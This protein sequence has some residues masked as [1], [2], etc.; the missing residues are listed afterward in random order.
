M[1]SVGIS[2]IAIV[3]PK[4]KQGRCPRGTRQVML[5]VALEDPLG[6]LVGGKEGTREV[7]TGDTNEK[8]IVLV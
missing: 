3:L 8:E 1:P 4:F 7:K 5:P 6:V 2:Y